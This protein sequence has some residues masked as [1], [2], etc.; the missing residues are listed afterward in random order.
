MDNEVTFIFGV[1]V[2]S[3]NKLFLAIIVIH[4]VLGLICIISGMV[5]MLS[6][7][8]TKIHATAGK[9][10]YWGMTVLFITVVITSLMRWPFNTHLLI[11]G[12]VAYALTF[13]GQRVA[14][15]HRP[16]WTRLHTVSMGL[17][18]VLL[19]TGFYVDN[20]KNLPFW[21]QFP[22]LFFWLFPAAIGIP[23]IVYV[24]Y[25]HPLNKRKI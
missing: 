8:T 11:V 19:L 22:Q 2:P 25:R 12:T 23:I 24:F 17:S 6:Q 20:G 9:T 13:V 10:Y 21:N 16:N 14:K 3:D 15:S 4:I 7:K 5:A 1:P 18:F